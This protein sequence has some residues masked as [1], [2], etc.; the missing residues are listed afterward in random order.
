MS[1]IL[2]HL[3]VLLILAYTCSWARSAILAAGKSRAGMFL[4]LLFLHFHSFS[5]LFCLSPSSPLLSLPS[6]F[7]LFQGEDPK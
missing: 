7:S 6:L 1:C 4:F 3:G 5:F 2:H